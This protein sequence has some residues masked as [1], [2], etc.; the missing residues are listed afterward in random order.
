LITQLGFSWRILYLQP[1]LIIEIGRQWASLRYSIDQSPPTIVSALTGLLFFAGWLGG[2]WFAVE[3][4]WRAA[5]LGSLPLVF[6]LLQ[7]FLSNARTGFIWLSLFVASPY[8]A[9]LVLLPHRAPSFNPRRILEGALVV[10]AFVAFYAL[11]QG[12]REGEGEQRTETTLLKT[13]VSTLSPPMS[14]SHWLR[15]DWAGIQPSW[16]ERSFA[17]V[18]DQLGIARRGQGLGWES[19]LEIET[20]PNVYTGFRQLIEDVTVPGSIVLFAVLGLVVGL[21]YQG[22]RTAR[23]GWLPVLAAF[24][25]L[26]IGSYVALWTTYNSCLLGWVLFAFA[27]GRFGPR[28]LRPAP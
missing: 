2:L 13:R 28:L 8:L 12:L 14:L 5:A 9:A 18:F 20:V 3:R 16:G 1:A 19:D 26:T 7:A 17:G 21:A 22:V 27:V 15:Q 10:A 11:V 23:V 4:S 25:S 6:G 24:Y